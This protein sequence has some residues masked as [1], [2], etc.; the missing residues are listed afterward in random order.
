MPVIARMR[1]T[2]EAIDSSLMILNRP[3]S[4]VARTCV[5]PQSSFENIPSS[6]LDRKHAHL[7]AVLLAKQRHRARTHRFFDGHLVSLHRLVAEDVIVDQAFD[8]FL[9]CGGQRLIMRE[10]ETQIIRRHD[11]AGLFDVRTQNFAQ[12][13]MHQVRRRVIASRR[14]AFLDVDFSRQRCRQL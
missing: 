7:L 1:R 9:L 8:L 12:R 6:A 4:P 13:R 14:I 11:R 3:M 5:P 10:V 2:P